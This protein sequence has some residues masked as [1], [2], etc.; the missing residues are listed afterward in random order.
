M[1]LFDQKGDRAMTVDR[2]PCPHC[3]S[4]NVR[5]NGVNDSGNPRLFCKDCRKS[6]SLIDGKTMITEILWKPKK[7]LYDEGKKPCPH[8]GSGNISKKGKDESG[9]PRLV[10]NDCKRQFSLEVNPKGAKTILPDRPLTG[11][12]RVKR[13]LEKKK[14]LK[15]L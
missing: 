4:E 2:K 10:C 15:N 6:F 5:K 11:Y 12:E 13:C 9:N 7:D 14:S 3:G 1:L 8:C